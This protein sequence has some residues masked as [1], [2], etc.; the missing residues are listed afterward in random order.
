MDSNNHTLLE[1]LI[2]Y[3]K[4][5]DRNS[6]NTITNE[7][8]LIA[9]IDLVN[10]QTNIPVSEDE[11]RQL[12]DLLSKIFPDVNQNFMETRKKLYDHSLTSNGIADTMLF[13]TNLSRA[14]RSQEDQA[15]PQSDA[16][17]LVQ[18]LSDHPSEALSSIFVNNTASDDAQDV[19]K[20]I[21]IDTAQETDKKPSNKAGFINQLINDAK[22]KKPRE[23]SDD[24]KEE[25]KKDPVKKYSDPKDFLS[26]L[27]EDVKKKYAE[28]SKIVLGQEHAVSQFTA[29][30]F[31]S[32][33]IAKTAE[34]RNRPRA[35]FLFAGPPGVGKTFLAES[36]AKMLDLPF[37]R[38][39]M[40]EYCDKE[41]AIEF[42]G[43]D[44][45]YKNGK[46]GNFT[47]F[48]AENPKS[49][50]LFDEIEKAHLNIIHLFLQ[51]L[52]AG[53]IRDSFTDEELSLKDTIL[54]FT[55]NAGKQLYD[56][57]DSKNLSLLSKK[58]I[59]KSLETDINPV[60][61]QPFFPSAI[62][63]RF[64]TGNVVMF[65]HLPAEILRRIAI[66]QI[67][68]HTDSF[69]KTF[70]IHFDI[71]E[72]VYTALL[73]SEGGSVDGRTIKARAEAFFYD[74][75]FELLRLIT[76]EKASASVK[77]IDTVKIS[78][79]LPENDPETARLFHDSE[80]TSVL[81]F[82]DEKTV[83]KC[84]YYA[85]DTDILGAQDI[86][87]S[88]KL[89]R[90]NDIRYIL[91]DLK[92]SQRSADQGYLN[93][94]DIES[95]ARD[96]LHIIRES[97]TDVPVFVLETDNYTVSDEEKISFL[98]MG[99]ESFI[100]IR[101][102]CEG[103]NADLLSISRKLHQ[104]NGINELARANKLIRF[105]TAQ[106]FDHEN[107]IAHIKLFDLKKTVAVDAED[108]ENILSNVSKPDVDFNRI[109]GAEDAKSELKYFVD[110]LKNP[111]KFMGTGVSAPKG[112]LLYGPPGTGKT[113]LAKATATASDVTFISAVGS[114]FIKSLHGQGKDMLLDMFRTARK[115][116]PS[117]IFIDEIDTIARTRT[118][119]N[120]SV[121]VED[122]L[123]ALLAEMDGFKSNS[124]KP[125]FVLAATNYDPAA[126]GE[127]SLDPAVL[128][129]FD[130]RIFVDLP[131]RDERKKYLLRRIGENAIFSVSE[132][133]IDNIA[134][135]STGMS[136]AQLASVIELAMRT[137]IKDGDLKV[138]DAIL[139]ES[140]EEF[141]SG[142]KKTWND[143]LLIRVA[144]HEAGHAFLCWQSGETP[145][146]LTIVARG[147]HG[148]YMQHEDNEGKALYSRKELRDRIRISLGG[149]ASEIV[150]Y[151][152]EDG[153]STG[154]RG[155][156]QS[157]TALA[158]SM[159]CEYGMS[160]RFGLAAIGID[161]TAFRDV[162]AEIYQ[163]I[164]AILSEELEKAIAILSAN[165]AAI[166]A[167][168]D[169]LMIKNHL[170]GDEINAVFEKHAVQVD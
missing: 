13:N 170:T 54:I 159:I 126:T 160:E 77:G 75:M 140:F 72:N 119:S 139:D 147:S 46:R 79:K 152:A 146:Y 163:E 32:E 148:G 112:V 67:K 50:I 29:G 135:R 37:E 17:A 94:E 154:A 127:K 45:V 59:L 132:E 49:V 31:R 109:I 95:E 63:S 99:V 27:T 81:V 90:E 20:Q 64:A 143:D 38:Y 40:S 33:L 121:G 125:V 108:T 78:L 66:D 21:G 97:Y 58:V 113:M 98:S 156:L 122:I 5:L 80:R 87:S 117:I 25:P 164:N 47:K 36:V 55:T 85:P 161:P 123:T 131:N 74:E 68:K 153:V 168:V 9:V 23:K 7:R 14:L 110:Y 43:S 12:A 96:F 145:S 86:T 10:H 51:I 28:L 101:S 133:K 62:C 114:Q 169:E 137:A 151:G 41:A 53:K 39:D 103:L 42:I 158:R 142:E 115:Y 89:L 84:R 73:Y 150:Y 19:I 136:L 129:R 155:D 92:H 48:I 3:G 111:K 52:D 167:I 2:A 76:S 128:R 106:S 157:A 11:Y 91:I 24:Q 166:N 120:N 60:T 57:S 69:E 83:E 8:F 88:K 34:E 93:M 144:R 82:S 138:T 149:R 15:A 26:D 35:T 70:N 105:E 6:S 22:S 118:G 124:S 107:H 30:F 61:G 165:Q 44:A 116:A 4:Q 162:A 18:Y 130:R 65:N 1:Q 134:M 104:R 71:D 100:S 16:L 102:S 56:T 141:N